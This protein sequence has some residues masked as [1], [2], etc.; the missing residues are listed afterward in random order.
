MTMKKIKIA[1]FKSKLSSHLRKV[2][3]GEEIVILDRKQPIAKVIPITPEKEVKLKLIP[4]R[5]KG[6]WKA[7]VFPP[8]SSYIDIVKIL[9]DDRDRR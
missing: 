6:D 7:L 9:R 2:R 3:K 8:H 1:E 4:P 5:K